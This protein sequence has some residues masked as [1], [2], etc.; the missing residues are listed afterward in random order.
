MLTVN[1]LKTVCDFLLC[2]TFA[3]LIGSYGE[4]W[5]VIGAVLMLGFASSLILQKTSGTLPARIL[6]GLLPPVL[7]GRNPADV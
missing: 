1:A 6:C 2:F 3:T 4:A 7:R 5:P